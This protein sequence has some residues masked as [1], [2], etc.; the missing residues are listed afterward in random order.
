[1]RGRG[2]A[3]LVIP[4]ADPGIQIEEQRPGYVRYRRDDGYRWEVHGICDK[5]GDCLIGAKVEGYEGTG[6]NGS[7]GSQ[8]DLKKAQ[9]E[10]G[11][12]RVDSEFDVPVLP[13]FVQCCASDGTLTFVELEPG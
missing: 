4:T 7:I 9:R 2:G 12:E 1:M 8:T 13:H 6:E 10:L 3:G 11:K 5:R